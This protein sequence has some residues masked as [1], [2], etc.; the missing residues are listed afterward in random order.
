MH[1]NFTG[2]PVKTVGGSMRPLIKS[3]EFIFTE[4]T[5]NAGIG[6]VVAYKV[7]GTIFVHR[8][9][10]KNGADNF[11][12]NGDSA[13][14]EEHTINKTAIIGKI[15]Q[16]FFAEN[17]FGLIYYYLISTIFKICRPIKS[18]LM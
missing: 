9:I 3:G 7:D 10:K 18:I 12:V 16:P 17:F 11:V 13:V 5:K 2:K 4:K 8:I 15:K 14:T 6:D 1:H